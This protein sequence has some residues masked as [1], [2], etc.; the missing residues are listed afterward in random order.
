M[1]VAI[2]GASGVGKSTVARGVATGTGLPHLNT[3]LTYRAATFAVLDRGI[4]PHD[5]AAVQDVVDRV[6]MEIEGEHVCVDGREITGELRSEAV[7]GAVSVVAAHPKLR[8]RI[9]A[10]QRE[11]VAAR[12]GSAVVEGRDIGTVVF[13]EAPVKVFL[14]ARPEI[15]AQRRS[16]D[17]EAAGKAMAQVAED[18]RRRDRIDSTRETSP[19]RAAEDAVVI[20]TSDM[21]AEEVVAAVLDLVAAAARSMRQR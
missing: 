1:L 19:L 13:P 16:G 18:L 9:V 7:T 8:E 12:G 15:R 10:I 20:D 11:W 5:A 2:D 17:T 3:G 6:N 21:S 4:D 14:T